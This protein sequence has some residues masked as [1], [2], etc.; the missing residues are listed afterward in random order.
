[1]GCSQPNQGQDVP[2]SRAITDTKT[3][4]MITM[5]GITTAVVPLG[6]RLFVV[7]NAGDII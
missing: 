1:M 4:T 2:F 7:Q 3:D 5:I 6:V